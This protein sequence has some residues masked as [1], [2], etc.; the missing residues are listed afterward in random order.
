MTDAEL[1]KDRLVIHI[2]KDSPFLHN[3]ESVVKA[4]QESLDQGVRKILVTFG[5]HLIPFSR[6]VSV[7]MQ[8]S[9]LAGQYHGVV[10]VV[11]PNE[12][13]KESLITLGLNRVVKFCNSEDD[14]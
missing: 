2:D 8:C 12:E 5:D 13:A 10:G 3:P 4:V 6:L 14:L 1:H 9:K 7:I 11:P